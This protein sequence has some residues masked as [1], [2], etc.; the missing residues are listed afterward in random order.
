VTSPVTLQVL[1]TL[2]KARIDMALPRLEKPKTEIVDV[3]RL[4][5][6][7]EKLLP[8]FAKSMTD[9]LLMLPQTDFP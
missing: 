1:P 5:L 7:M 6:L 8:R 2:V 9:M 3:Q 4:K